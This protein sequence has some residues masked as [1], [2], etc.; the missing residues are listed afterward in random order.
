MNQ[1]EVRIDIVRRGQE[2][3]DLIAKLP[4]CVGV[5]YL[6]QAVEDNERWP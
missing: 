1:E 4:P 3:F 6:V 5:R 2:G